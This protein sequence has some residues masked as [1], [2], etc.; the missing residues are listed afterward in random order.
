MRVLDRTQDRLIAANSPNSVNQAA[1]IYPTS[2][3][4]V[5]TARTSSGCG[6]S[7][8]EHRAH[9]TRAVSQPRGIVKMGSPAFVRGIEEETCGQPFRRGQ[10]TT[11]FNIFDERKNAMKTG[12][13]TKLLRLP[14][15]KNRG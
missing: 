10:E 12:V 9:V 14:L 3:R 15:P 5:S 6:V 2:F 11:A 13:V 1:M 8:T 4:P 7:L